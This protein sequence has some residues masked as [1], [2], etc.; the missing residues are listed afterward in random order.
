[1]AGL[2]HK[3]SSGPQSPSIKFPKIDPNGEPAAAFEAADRFWLMS[4]LLAAGKLKDVRNIELTHLDWGHL[5]G[6]LDIMVPPPATFD[7]AAYLTVYPDVNAAV[8]DGRF[9][10]GY[11][12]YLHFGRLERRIRPFK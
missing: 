9:A 4:H 10:N 11:M 8:G 6:R 12:H 2:Y 5:I 3:K 1:M 7:E